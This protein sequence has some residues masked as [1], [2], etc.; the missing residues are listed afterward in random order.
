[1]KTIT[2]RQIKPSDLKSVYSWV[3]DIEK[4]DTFIMLNAD[5]PTSFKEE[6]EY[7]RDLFKKTKQK[8]LVKIAVFDGKKYL[9]SCDIEKGGKRQGHIGIFGIVLSKE[10][11]GQGIGFRLARETIKL[12]QTKLGIKKIVLNCFANNKIGISFYKKLGFKQN[13]R[14]PQAV[15]Y[16]GKYV[17]TIW[18]YKDLS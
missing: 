3:K 5:E 16:Q 8:K 10:C 13:C 17:D 18:F 12:A 4:E 11:R 9:G 2:F 15:F 14:D 1:M 6:K 7:F